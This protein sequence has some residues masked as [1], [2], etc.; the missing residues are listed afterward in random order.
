MNKLQGI[1]CSFDW[2]NQAQTLGHE[3]TPKY[4]SNHAPRV[5]LW[6]QS[7]FLLSSSR[8][9]EIL[10]YLESTKLAATL[11]L[12]VQLVQLARLRSNLIF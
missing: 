7:M 4:L 2:V 9:E 1:W 10:F 6:D 12:V 5:E 11:I 8:R 3:I